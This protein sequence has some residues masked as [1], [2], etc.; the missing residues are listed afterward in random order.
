MALLLMLSLLLLALVG[1][2]PGAWAACPAA[3]DLKPADRPRVCARLYEKSDAYY[4]NCCAGAELSLEP[5]ADLPYLPS[6]WYHSASSLVVGTRCELT[7]WYRRGKGGKTRKFSAGAHPRLAEYR[8]GIFG[9]WNNAI[10]A[11]Y[12]KCN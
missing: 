7:V 8:R 4:E 12:C 6:G 1:A 3:A 5:G 10:G 9:D 2:L 11:L